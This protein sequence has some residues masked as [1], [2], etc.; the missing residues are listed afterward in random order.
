MLDG[1]VSDR[2]EKWKNNALFERK[3]NTLKELNKEL[4]Q[5]AKELELLMQDMTNRYLNKLKK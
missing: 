4:E 5:E 1:F 2:V 3:S